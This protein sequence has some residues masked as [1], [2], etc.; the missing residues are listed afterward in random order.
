VRVL[1]LLLLA[2]CAIPVVSAGNY[3]P[4]GDLQPGD[5]HVSASLEAGRVLAGPSDVG[6]LATIPPAAQQWEVTTWVASDISLR[7]QVSRRITLEGQLK[8]TNPIDP[9]VPE[10][11]GGALGARFRLLEHP[12]EGGLAAELGVRVVGISATQNLTQTQDGL[13]QTDTWDYRA[14]GVEVPLVLTYRINSLMAV[15]L[16]PFTRLYYIRAWHTEVNPS[17]QRTQNALFW[18]PVLS[19]GVAT[20]F[21]FDLGP[22]ELAPGVAIELATKP[23]PSTPTHLLFEPGL[24]V[25]TRF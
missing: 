10:V 8:L 21:A 5:F 13:T 11:V 14:L 15:T 17:G 9:F 23:G 24:S 6:D 25:G 12:P 3:L 19:G 16:S 7:Y 4:A 2:G 1:A 20:S 18:T 22:I